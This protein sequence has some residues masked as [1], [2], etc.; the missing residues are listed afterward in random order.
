MKKTFSKQKVLRKIG[1][2]CIKFRTEKKLSQ[3]ELAAMAGVSPAYIGRVER[4][5]TCPNIDTL[6]K[7]A[8][9]LE[10]SLSELTNIEEDDGYIM[11]KYRDEIEY[12]LFMSLYP[13]KVMKVIREI[14]EITNG[15]LM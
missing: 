6:Y 2:R 14:F 1:E 5:E 11:D 3:K 15:G 4:G 13:D 8:N 12:I 10:I 7:I 9:A